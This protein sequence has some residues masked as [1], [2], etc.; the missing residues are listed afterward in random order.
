LADAA[1]PRPDLLVFDLRIQGRSGHELLVDRARQLR[2]RTVPVA[3]VTSSTD[4]T[5]RERS[6]GLGA[7]MHVRKPLNAEGFSRLADMLAAL[8][9]PPAAPV[10]RD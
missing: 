2:L 9:E 10:R 1:A 5:E 8:V 6:L 4:D 3:V 7:S